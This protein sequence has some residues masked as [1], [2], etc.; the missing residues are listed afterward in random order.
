M[1]I[2]NE[3]EIANKNNN[4]ESVSDWLEKAQSAIWK[5]GPPT[6]A[7]LKNKDRYARNT[8]LCT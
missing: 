3:S 8:I 6:V 4:I 1:I 5:K 7:F 2:N